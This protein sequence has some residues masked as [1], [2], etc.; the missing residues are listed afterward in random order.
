[1]EKDFLNILDSIKENKM[2]CNVHP[3]EEIKWFFKPDNKL[4]CVLCI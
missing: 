2:N 4:M 3:L 1:M